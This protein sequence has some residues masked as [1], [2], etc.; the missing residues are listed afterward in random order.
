MTNP[1]PTPA[2]FR[3]LLI[4]RVVD[5]VAG[6][7]EWQALEDVARSDPL[8]WRDVAL[9][10][11]DH[12]ELSMAVARVTA[13]ADAVGLPASANY[14]FPGRPVFGK[15]GTYL[16]WAAAAA[17]AIL[18]YRGGPAPTGPGP[19]VAGLFPADVGS[20][21]AT[22]AEALDLYVTKG[23]QTGRVIEELP[24]KILVQATPV[25]D[26]DGDRLE[27]VYIRQI[28]ERTTVPMLYRL[29]PDDTGQ[30]LVPVPVRVE[31]QPVPSV[32]GPM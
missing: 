9:A 2:D 4:S 20:S 3:D 8:V 26:A 19:Q 18:L 11:R 7:Q 10:Q 30:V 13:R 17:L 27:I 12:A 22:P 29:A 23:R 25:S 14:V 21:P 28:V 15:V 31:P 24:E 1:E 32:R 5:G 16:G 6:P